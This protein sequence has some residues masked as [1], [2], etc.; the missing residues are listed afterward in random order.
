MI[1]NKLAAGVTVLA[2]AT[3]AMSVPA[4][5]KNKDLN[6]L[7]AI[8]AGG[9]VINEIIDNKKD[10]K[11]EATTVTHDEYTPPRDKRVTHQHRDGQWYTHADLA[12]LRSYHRNDRHRD[13]DR[14]WDHD[15]RHEYHPDRLTRR[16]I[17]D[18]V[19]KLPIPKKCRRNKR[20]AL[21]QNIHGVSRK[22]LHKRGYRINR[23][24]VVSH[25]KWPGLRRRPN[26]L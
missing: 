21:G 15:D 2:I 16:P 18:R 13:T 14:N 20:D 24:G 17:Q 26:L 3:T 1:L 5:A 9:L 12:E 6:T 11:R 10:R 22:C 4:K 23:K 25:H 7:L 8:L 19:S